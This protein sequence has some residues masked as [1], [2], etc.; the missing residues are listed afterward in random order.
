M[1]NVCLLGGTGSIGTQVLDLVRKDSKYHLYAFS[2]GKNLKQAINIIEE[3]SPK[4]VCALSQEDADYLKTNYPFLR[5]FYGDDGLLELVSLKV[6]NYMVINALVGSVGLKPTYV[7]LENKYDVYLANKETL[8]V[9]GELITCLAE[10]NNCKIIPIDSE[11]SAIFQL[12]D[13]EDE[14]E[15]KNLIITASG[16]SLRDLKREDLDKVTINDVLNHPTWQMGKKITVDSATMMNKGFEVIEAHYLFNVDVDHIKVMIHRTS[17]IHSM[18]EFND[19]SICAQLAS[20]DMHL[21]IHYAIYGKKHTTCDIIKPLSLDKGLN[22]I[23]EPF[24]NVRYPLVEIAKETLRKGGI[25]PCILNAS[26]EASVALFLEGKIKFLD[27]EKNIIAALNDHEYDKYKNKP[28]TI[29]L[30]L[31]VDKAVKG[32]VGKICHM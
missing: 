18:I 10:K 25:Y 6:S 1:I 15:I 32:K 20:A 19:H 9:G 29:D 28:L 5:T 2:F 8:V 31:E 23:L 30:L 26:N 13:S 17:T 11:H 7:A 16:G 21:P 24:D 14:K 22:L 27:I 3:F 4:V 12:L